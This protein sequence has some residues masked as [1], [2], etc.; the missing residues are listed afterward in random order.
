M[1]VSCWLFLNNLYY[2]ARIHEHQSM[3]NRYEKYESM[4]AFIYT[5]IYL[6][7]SVKHYYYL[8]KV[9]PFT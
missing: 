8:A 2:D 4:C 7:Q 5:G 9:L 1:V 3:K 6:H